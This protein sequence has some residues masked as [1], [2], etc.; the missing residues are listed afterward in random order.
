MTPIYLL[1][2]YIPFPTPQTPS[3]IFT[4][5]TFSKHQESENKILV[6]GWG[7]EIGKGGRVLLILSMTD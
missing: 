7:Y 4:S 1:K 6:V 5:L 2:G 3:A